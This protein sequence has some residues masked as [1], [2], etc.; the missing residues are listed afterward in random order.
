MAGGTGGARDLRVADVPDEDVPEGVLAL[1]LH[2]A[3]AG[4]RTSSLRASSCSA[5]SPRAGRGRPSRRARPPRTPCRA[6]RRP[7]AGSCAPAGSVSRRAAISAC[8]DS[9]TSSSSLEHAAVGEQAH[10][11][12]RVQR[13][14]ARP[15]EQRLLRLGRQHRPLEQRRDELGGL[16]VAERSEVD[17]LRVAGVRA[18]GRDAARRARAARC[19]AAGAARPPPSRRV[20]EEG[21]QRRVGPVQVLED[22]HRRR[23]RQRGLAEA[24]PGRERLLLRGGLAGAPTSGARRARSQ[25]RSGSSAGSAS[26]ELR[27]GLRGRVRLE[28][29]ALGLHDLAERPERDPVAVGQAAALAPATSPGRSST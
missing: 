4:G 18:E 19:R 11:L 1:A 20:L 5:C 17:P 8:T 22:E 26:L 23:A 27:R 24:P 29:P 9:G 28:D 13:V 6:P 2:R 10:E 3:R 12:L 21:E 16:R 25:A 7:G 15:L 14:A